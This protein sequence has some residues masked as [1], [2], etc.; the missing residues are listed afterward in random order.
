MFKARCLAVFVL[1]VMAVQP[2]FADDSAKILGIWKLV[3]FEGE[4]QDTGERT[5]WEGKNPTGYIIFTPEV[6]V[7][8]VIDRAAIKLTVSVKV[9]VTWGIYQAAFG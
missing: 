6:R 8:S 1:L 9:V 4:F 2:A 7:D 5:D 3:S